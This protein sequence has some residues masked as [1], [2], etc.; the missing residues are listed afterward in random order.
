MHLLFNMY[1]LWVTGQV[2]EPVLGRLRFTALYLLS[3]LGG[4]VAVLL[5][6]DP[7][8]QSWLV[9]VLGAS[10]AVFGLFGALLVVL[11]R[12]KGNANQILI[13][14]GINFVISFVVPNIS[15]QGHLGGLVVGAA[16]GAGFAYVPKHQRQLWGVL[17]PTIT[18]I[19]LILLSV[20]KY[21][22]V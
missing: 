4:S 16:M 7:N 2:L 6:A 12:F 14:L 17:I 15:W 21:A 11:R 20:L 13:L 8:A 5:L 18:A 1:A 10:G 22:S 19:V 3:A 9:P